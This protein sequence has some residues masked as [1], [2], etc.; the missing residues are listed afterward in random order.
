MHANQTCNMDETDAKIL[1]MLMKNSRT[2]Y[3]E[4]AKEAGISDVA[5]HKRIKKLE[6]EVIKAFT[7]LIRQQALG[8]S[9]TCILGIKCAAGEVGEIAA[10]LA[11]IEDVTEVYTTFGEY[12][13]VVKLRSGDISTLR[14]VVEGKISSIPGIHQLR[15]SIVFECYKEKP[16]LVMC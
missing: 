7:V 4:I 1:R 16:E 13:L 10:K 11:E 15:A 12:D 2:P 5:V 6:S 9:T 8:K 3:R 14:E